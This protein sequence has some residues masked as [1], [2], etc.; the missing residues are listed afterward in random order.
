[1]WKTDLWLEGVS[2]EKDKLGLTHTTI[3]KTDS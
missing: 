1:M 2:Q 3:L